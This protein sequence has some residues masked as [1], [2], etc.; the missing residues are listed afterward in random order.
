[1]ILGNFDRFTESVS[2]FITLTTLLHRF[3]GSLDIIGFH[4]TTS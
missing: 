1:M 3:K 2:A 4:K